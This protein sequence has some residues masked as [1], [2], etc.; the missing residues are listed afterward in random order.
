MPLFYFTC[1]KCGVGKK[2]LLEP[3]DAK[4]ERSCSEQG[5]L[6]AMLRDQRPPSTHVKETLD[7]GLMTRKVERFKDIEQL[8][9]DRANKDYTKE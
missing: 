4:K 6:G 8:M 3:E 5:C 1:E 7:N 2:F 9:H